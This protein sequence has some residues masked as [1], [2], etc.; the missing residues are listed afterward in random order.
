M[1]ERIRREKVPLR[2][3]CSAAREALGRPRGEERGGDIMRRHAHSLLQN[4]RVKPYSRSKADAHTGRPWSKP[5]NVVVKTTYDSTSIRRPFDCLS[6]VIK[7]T[8]T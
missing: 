4:S 2:C 1:C 8:V 3:V 7:V 5:T 6:K